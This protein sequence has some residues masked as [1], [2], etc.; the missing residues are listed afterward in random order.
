MLSVDTMKSLGNLA[1]CE[2]ASKVSTFDS[3][4]QS[5]IDENIINKLNSNYYSA[6]EFQSLNKEE[7]FNIYHSNLHGIESKFELLHNFVNTTKM[8][9]GII[10]TKI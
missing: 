6:Q 4:K 5:D 3:L 8:S 9:I 2:I 1:S 7:T 10:Y